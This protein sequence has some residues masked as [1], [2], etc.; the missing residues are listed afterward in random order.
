MWTHECCISSVRASE[1]PSLPVLSI[2]IDGFVEKS[3]VPE[4]FASVVLVGEPGEDRCPLP[5]DDAGSE[6]R[7]EDHR[8]VGTASKVERQR[9]AGKLSIMTGKEVHV[10]SIYRVS[11]RFASLSF[12]LTHS[13]LKF[14]F[15]L[16]N[17][18]RFSGDAALSS[19]LG[20]PVELNADRLP[21]EAYLEV[22]DPVA[23]CS[24]VQSTRLSLFFRNFENVSLRGQIDGEQDA[25]RMQSDKAQR[26]ACSKY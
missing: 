11:H 8:P 1:W 18:S 5:I 14:A 25:H 19:Q 4:R 26:R 15:V 3:L 6:L 12:R 20:R 7:E 16:T 9:A 21:L 24:R 17:S 22:P 10:L 23:P 2:G 13:P